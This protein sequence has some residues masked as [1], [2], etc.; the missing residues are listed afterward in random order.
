MSEISHEASCSF[1]TCSLV[2]FVPRALIRTSYSALRSP[3]Y[4]PVRNFSEL[5]ALPLR[6]V[7]ADDGHYEIRDGFKRFSS[8]SEEGRRV[9]PVIV[10]NSCSL[11]ER[12]QLLLSANAP[13]RTLSP[14][15]EG[16]VVDSLMKE[17]GLSV[18][19]I[20]KLLGHKKE[21]VCKRQA[22]ATRLSATAGELLV[23][24][25][26]S[27]T[28]A[29]H[30][31]SLSMENQDSLL[32]S[33][34]SHH[35]S[36]QELLALVQAFRIAEQKPER[37]RLLRNPLGVLRPAAAPTSSV[38]AQRLEIHIQQISQT[39]SELRSFSIPIDLS[40]AEQ[41]RLKALYRSACQALL[42]TVS[43]LGLRNCGPSETVRNAAHPAKAGKLSLSSSHHEE[44]IYEKSISGS[45][46]TCPISRSGPSRSSANSGTL[47]D[48]VW[49]SENRQAH[50]DLSQGCSADTC[51]TRSDKRVRKKAGTKNRSISGG[52]FSES[53]SRSDDFPNSSRDKGT[54]LHGRS[55]HAGG[56]C[57]VSPHETG[58]S[59]SSAFCQKAF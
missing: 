16:R 27:L 48:A 54:W 21:W 12:K 45:K 33:A 14:L 51:R 30:L 53:S 50:G 29:H 32:K 35:L 9:I 18:S 37:R 28:I 31:T 8:W 20:A 26:L 7:P 57:R 24:G 41:R 36:R 11:P 4:S 22:L 47:P 5:V 49:H 6:V 38:R 34:D 1:S 15:D 39:L 25:K 46:T 56:V 13:R 17:D 59:E 43:E 10:E 3:P 42:Q 23:R 19:A 55:H 52:D 58:H 44:T 2:K 40:P